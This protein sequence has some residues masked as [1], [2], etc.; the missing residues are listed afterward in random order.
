MRYEH[1]KEVPPNRGGIFLSQAEY[2][3]TARVVY[4]YP[5]VAERARAANRKLDDIFHPPAPTE[6]DRKR[7]ALQ[8]EA[9]HK[10]CRETYVALAGKPYS[11]RRTAIFQSLSLSYA[12]NDD[13]TIDKARLKAANIFLSK[14]YNGTDVEK[15]EKVLVM[16]FITLLQVCGALPAYQEPDIEPPH[17][18]L[19]FGVAYRENLIELANH[20]QDSAGLVRRLASTYRQRV[21]DAMLETDSDTR[22]I[23][24]NAYR[25]YRHPFDNTPFLAQEN[26][27]GEHIYFTEAEV[28]GVQNARYASTLDQFMFL[29]DCLENESI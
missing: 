22:H 26:Y 10:K 14:R 6:S 7:L 20:Q 21:V 9:S 24:N 29:K 17:P 28:P 13:G 15:P 16:G 8:A 1:L 3:Y 12:I 19:V 18:L 4:E 27:K 25:V 5:I 23:N 2:D 11:D